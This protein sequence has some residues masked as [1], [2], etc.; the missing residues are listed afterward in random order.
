MKKN[1]TINIFG[2]LYAIDEDAYELLNK[3]LGSTKNYFANAEGGDEIA[4]DIEH[5]V[6]ELLWNKK[7]QGAAVVDIDDIK[8]I[9]A[10][11]GSPSEIDAAMEHVGT[12]E[13]TDGTA[14]GNEEEPDSRKSGVIDFLRGR[15]LYRNDEEKVLGGVCSGLATF[16]GHDSPVMVRLSAVVLF[17][18]L[19]FCGNYIGYQ[20]AWAVPLLYI[21]MWA[22]VPLPR[23]TEDRLRMNGKKVTLENINKEFLNEA[24]APAAADERRRRSNGSGCLSLLLKS[25]LV[26]LLLPFIFA[27]GCCV[28]LLF[29]AILVLVNVPANVFPYW[30]STN[31]T[32]E[33]IFISNNSGMMLTTIFCMIALIAIPVYFIIKTL[34]HNSKGTSMRTAFIA[35]MMWVALAA[36]AITSCISLSMNYDKAER[37]YKSRQEQMMQN[38]TE[39]DQDAEATDTI[40]WQE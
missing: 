35:I 33:E 26:L 5:R 4:D 38:D 34:R 27:F 25:L 36:I 17:F 11:I 37:D 3:Y 30:T 18:F 40:G 15:Y 28:F 22:I 9:I 1:L 10:K 16:L 39:D 23:S 14:G 12:A 31:G 7:E 19:F 32:A 24:S 29:A 6:A 8:D 13:G 20:F 2:Q 21:I